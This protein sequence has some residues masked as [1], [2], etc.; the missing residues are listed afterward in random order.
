VYE[1][2]IRQTNGSSRLNASNFKKDIGSGFDTYQGSNPAAWSHLP[3]TT[4]GCRRAGVTQK[5][6]LDD[7]FHASV[8]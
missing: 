6:K 5:R 4:L 1:S 8:K 2:L 7:P 3:L